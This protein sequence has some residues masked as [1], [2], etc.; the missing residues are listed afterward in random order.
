MTRVGVG[1]DFGEVGIG[2]RTTS[3]SIR[4][5]ILVFMVDWAWANEVWF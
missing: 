4:A 1:G 2:V 5:S 3:C